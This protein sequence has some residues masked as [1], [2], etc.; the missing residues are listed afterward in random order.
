VADGITRW[1]FWKKWEAE[2]PEKQKQHWDFVA[3]RAAAIP[4]KQREEIANYYK[5]MAKI[6]K[7]KT[8]RKK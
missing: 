6:F 7:P 5:R 1:E 4:L 8:A 2:S 3:E